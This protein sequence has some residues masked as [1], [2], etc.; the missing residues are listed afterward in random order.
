MCADGYVNERVIRCP[1]CYDKTPD[2]DDCNGTGKFQ[3][4]D[5][6]EEIELE[7][8]RSHLEASDE[9]PIGI[10]IERGLQ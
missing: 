5:N 8:A 6:A 7:A 4:P 10:L 9:E 2:C 3:T 1:E